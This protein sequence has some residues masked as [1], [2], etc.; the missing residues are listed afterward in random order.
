VERTTLHIKV[1]HLS[2]HTHAVQLRQAPSKE[3]TP[4][5]GGRRPAPG[6]KLIPLARANNV[7]IMLTQFGSFDG[8]NA[9]LIKAALLTGSER[10]GIEHLSLL[11]QIAPTA[12]EVKALKAY[13][14]ALS[15]L[16]APEQ[17]LAA[18]ADVPRLSDKV[19][20]LFLEASTVC[21]GWQG[22]TTQSR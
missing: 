5:S 8:G 13:R 10:L 20:P 22:L 7:S 6:V 17:F 2:S 15:E 9:A 18:L 14:G 21:L 12:E 3:N 4:G 11:L 1:N 19:G 16:S